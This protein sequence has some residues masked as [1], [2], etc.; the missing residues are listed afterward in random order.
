MQKIFDAANQY[1]RESDWKVLAVLKFCLLAMGTMIGI[2][3]L[4]RKKKYALPIC[5][6]IYLV[7]LVPLM[8]RY[9]DILKDS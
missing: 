9:I 3:V 6:I 1:C 2:V 4:E 8:K 7:T 5:G